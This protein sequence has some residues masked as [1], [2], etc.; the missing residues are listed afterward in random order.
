MSD[1]AF[2]IC[3]VCIKGSDSTS[4]FCCGDCLIGGTRTALE[5]ASFDSDALEDEEVD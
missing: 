3:I 2:G 4:A 1:E 5:N